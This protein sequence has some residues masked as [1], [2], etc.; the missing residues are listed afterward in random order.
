MMWARLEHAGC[1][2]AQDH[3]PSLPVF[4]AACDLADPAEWVLDEIGG[5]QHPF[6][7]LR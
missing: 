1:G 2:P 5:R 7:V 4:D 6:E 3:S